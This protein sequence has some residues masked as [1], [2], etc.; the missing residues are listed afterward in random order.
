MVRGRSRKG[1]EKISSTYSE[2]AEEVFLEN[3]SALRSMAT[4]PAVDARAYFAT[5][6]G[7][8]PAALRLVASALR[9]GGAAAS[10]TAG[11]APEPPRK[12][13]WLAGDSSLDNKFW[14]RGGVRRTPACNGEERAF[15]S[16]EPLPQDVA[17]CVNT[18]LAA[19]AGSSGG[20]GGGSSRLACVNAAVEES[21]LA[22]RAG[23]R[24]LPQDEVLRDTL[25]DG[26]VLVVSVGGND[27]A[28][29]SSLATKAALVALLGL[30]L[31]SC[32]GALC[33]PRLGGA[34]DAALE[35]G[36]ALGLAHL[37]RHFGEQTR[38]YVR[39]LLAGPQRARPAL[40]VI[41]M[42]VGLARAHHRECQR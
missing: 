37:T 36:S 34:S 29:S 26:D 33:P 3:D 12:L 18:L 23:G 39:A 14:L 13:I 27:I 25:A 24:L 32:C 6:H 19:R 7:H 30:P 31:P 38:D 15:G 40:V 9:E 10:A 11:D 22:D 4:P 17:H 20:G 21:R 28:L 35:D 42:I 41:C 8:D 1:R 5:Y 2:Q 16:A